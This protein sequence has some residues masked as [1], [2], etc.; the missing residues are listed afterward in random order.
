MDRSTLIMT[1]REPGF[2]EARVRHGGSVSSVRQPNPMV[3][4]RISNIWGVLLTNSNRSTF[5]IFK[6]FT[7]RGYCIPLYV[8]LA[9]CEEGIPTISMEWKISLV[10]KRYVS[11]GGLRHLDDRLV[12][13]KLSSKGFIVSAASRLRGLWFYI[14]IYGAPQFTSPPFKVRHCHAACYRVSTYP[15]GC[16]CPARSHRYHRHCTG[17]GVF[18]CILQRLP[19]SPRSLSWSKVGGSI[20]ILVG[21]SGIR[22]RSFPF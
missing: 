3:R 1:A 20:E 5:F 13:S 7:N 8:I 18:H 14:M 9:S 16:L 22:Q 19:P 15:S 17:L 4:R 6:S 11:V 21:I 12:T 10:H 2:E